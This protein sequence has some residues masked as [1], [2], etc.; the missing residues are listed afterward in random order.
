MKSVLLWLAVA[1][2]LLWVMGVVVLKVMSFAIHLALL[3]A[4]VLV[5]LHVVRK[6]TR[7]RHPR[8]L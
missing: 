6:A 8:G 3:A 1:L 7:G 4:V 2:V 5:V